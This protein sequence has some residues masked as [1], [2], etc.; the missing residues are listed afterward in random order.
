MESV[1]L[2]TPSFVREYQIGQLVKRVKKSF[3]VT[4]P[5]VKSHCKRLSAEMKRVYNEKERKVPDGFEPIKNMKEGK[6]IDNNK[7]PND[8]SEN[9]NGDDNNNNAS[10]ANTDDGIEQ[11]YKIGTAVSKEFLT[12]THAGNRTDYDSVTK[13]YQIIYEDGDSEDLNETE[14]SQLLLSYTAW[15]CMAA[16]VNGKEIHASQCIKSMREFICVICKKKDNASNKCL[17]IPVQCSA[18][19]RYEFNEFKQYHKTLNK[20]MRLAKKRGEEHKGCA[21]PMHVGCARWG[22]D[23]AKVNKKHLRMC[24]YFSGKPP[25]YNGPDEYQDPVSNC[26]CRIH[27]IEIQEGLAKSS[28]LDGGGGEGRSESTN[29][30]RKRKGG[31]DA[32]DLMSD[33]MIDHESDDSADKARRLRIAIAKKKKRRIMEESDEESE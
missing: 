11:K 5:E 15:F 12:G 21:E 16:P 3:E 6:V 2:L 27:A 25:T 29:N 24:Y 14:V 31:D 19:D 32:D 1:D 4:H 13:L 8:N 23:Y 26:F 20:Q 22:S 7:V 9:D 30:G 10:Q 28:L 18:G 33:V 17:R